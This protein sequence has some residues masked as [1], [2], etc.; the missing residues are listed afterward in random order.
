[1]PVCPRGATYLYKG[2][3][4]ESC[5]ADAGTSPPSDRL[6]VLSRKPGFPPEQVRLPLGT[7]GVTSWPH[8]LL[9]YW[10]HLIHE[11]I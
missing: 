3:R 1:M 10:T 8:G 6:G 9:C 5:R 11:C 7:C 2:S 4:S